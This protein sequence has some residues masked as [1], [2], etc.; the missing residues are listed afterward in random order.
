MK[1]LLIVLLFLPVV[2][3]GQHEC[4]G[5]RNCNNGTPID[6]NQAFDQ[7]IDQAFD[8][9]E[10]FGLGLSHSL[11]GV[12]VAQCLASTQWGSVIFSKQKVIFNLWCMAEVF[13][14]KGM[15][16]SAAQARCDIG[17]I[18]DWYEDRESCVKDQT[19]NPPPPEVKQEAK[20]DE[21]TVPIAIGNFDGF[22]DMD[23][24]LM[25]TQSEVESLEERIARI[26]SRQ[27]SAAIAAAKR[28]EIVQKT[29]EKL[30][31]EPDNHPK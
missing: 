7:N 24:N 19:W 22:D 26:E 1:I 4:Q 20:E 29:Y 9:D 31:N 28:Q 27:R 25:A 6:I 8:G 14:Q 16:H 15:F 11:G 5:N 3:F 17:Q 18:A 2:T 21:V 10:S 13:D 23:K 30:A 12:A